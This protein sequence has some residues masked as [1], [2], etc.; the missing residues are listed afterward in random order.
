MRFWIKFQKYILED[1]HNC[2]SINGTKSSACWLLLSDNTSLSHKKSVLG[3]QVV[4]SLHPYSLCVWTNSDHPS[5]GRMPNSTG[6]KFHTKSL[7]L[8]LTSN[9]WLSYDC[10]KQGDQRNYD[11]LK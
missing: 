6:E 11:Q 9:I 1:C 4:F 7:Q 10:S 2:V 5:G 8:N 3:I